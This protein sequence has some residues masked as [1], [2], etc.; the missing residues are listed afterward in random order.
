MIYTFC[1]SELMYTKCT[2]NI[3][4]QDVSHIS[5]KYIL[6]TKCSCHSSF[7]FVYEMYT[8]VCQNLVYILYTFC[9]HQLYIS[10]TIFV[11][12][13]YTQFPCGEQIPELLTINNVEPKEINRNKNICVTNVYEMPLKRKMVVLRKIMILSAH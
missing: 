2:Q 8:K 13:I 7:N 10:C 3:C 4:I 1:R 12:K 5:T 9:I 11:Y 6:Y